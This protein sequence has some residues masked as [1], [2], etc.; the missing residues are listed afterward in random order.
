M[1]KINYNATSSKLLIGLNIMVFMQLIVMF[2]LLSAMSEV[3][4]AANDI[5]IKAEGIKDL[6]V[7]AN[8]DEIAGFKIYTTK[9]GAVG[10][11]SP[12]NTL[13]PIHLGKISVDSIPYVIVK[14][15]PP[16][17][18][19]QAEAENAA[20]NVW[21][22]GQSLPGLQRN[23]KVLDV[24]IVTLNGNRLP[25]LQGNYYLPVGSVGNGFNVDIQ[26]VGGK[27]V[28]GQFQGSF[29]TPAIPVKI[30]K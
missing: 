14:D 15:M 1:E 12:D 23:N 17:E 9:S 22:L 21:A 5:S 29:D 10:Y 3:K 18:I 26:W 27:A 20:N 13:I 16:V 28:R 2:S 11:N 4:K 7:N 19:K 8:L 30:Q 25:V 24:N 6:K